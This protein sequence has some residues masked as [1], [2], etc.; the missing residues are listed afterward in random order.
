MLAK[1]LLDPRDSSLKLTKVI[2]TNDCWL[3]ALGWLR[4]LDSTIGCPI[5]SSSEAIE[6]IVNL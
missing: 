5:S 6:D 3:L 4:C 2:D 1:E